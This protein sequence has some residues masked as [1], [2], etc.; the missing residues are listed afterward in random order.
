MGR[1][2]GGIA[3]LIGLTAVAAGG[4]VC[5]RYPTPLAASATFSLAVVSILG[6]CVAALSI[7][8]RARAI[9]GSFAACG[10]VYLI[11]ALTLGPWSEVD[12]GPQMLTTP[13]IQVV[14]ER[15]RGETDE[16]SFNHS[17]NFKQKLLPASA[18]W[19]APVWEK[20]IRYGNTSRVLWTF[21]Q[22]AH[23]LL[24]L[25]TASAGGL[26]ACRSTR[27]DGDSSTAGPITL[28]AR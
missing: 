5:L 10:S 25:V 6:A 12:T 8:G 19:S 11:L 17:P 26:L 9:W 20:Y 24:A 2:W 27:R 15:I 3:R 23:S 13:L 4:L 1:A 28:E 14:E 7:P 18:Y 21:G 16:S 22:V